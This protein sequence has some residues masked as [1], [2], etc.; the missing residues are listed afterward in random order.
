M[1]A[2]FIHTVVDFVVMLRNI[3]SSDVWAIL[4]KNILVGCCQSCGYSVE[5]CVSSELF[6]TVL[7]CVDA[8]LDERGTKSSCWQRIVLLTDS[9]SYS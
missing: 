4:K 8:F 1:L 5:V 3:L 7:S 6:L 9:Y 2:S